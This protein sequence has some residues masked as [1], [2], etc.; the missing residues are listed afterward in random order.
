MFEEVRQVELLL[1]LH[2]PLVRRTV[3]ERDAV[4]LILGEGID[5][6]AAAG[7]RLGLGEKFARPGD[8]ALVLGSRLPATMHVHH[9]I[10]VSARVGHRLGRYAGCLPA[11]RADENIALR[12]RQLAGVF[13]DG[14]DRPTV[15]SGEV[16]R[17]PVVARPFRQ[18]WIEG[19]LPGGV[20]LYAERSTRVHPVP[21]HPP[22]TSTKLGEMAVALWAARGLERL[23]AGWTSQSGVEIASGAEGA[24]RAIKQPRLAVSNKQVLTSASLV[25]N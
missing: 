17:L 13:D 11:D 23:A 20:R 4:G 6:R 15:Q 22:V 25:R 14:S 7:E 24:A 9:V 8:A 12:R 18:K 19:L 21:L 3:G 16:V 2:Q 1:E 5:V 10:G